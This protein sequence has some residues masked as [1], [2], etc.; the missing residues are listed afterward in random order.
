MAQVIDDQSD[1]TRKRKPETDSLAAASSDAQEKIEEPPL[2]RP[3]GVE[4]RD[5]H[6]HKSQHIHLICVQPTARCDS[7]RSWI[8]RSVV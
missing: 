8:M 7:R 1:A 2:K 3:K 4:V 5:S 6:T